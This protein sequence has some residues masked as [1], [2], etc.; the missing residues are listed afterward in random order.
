MVVM[1]GGQMQVRLTISAEGRS[2]SRIMFLAAPLIAHSVRLVWV[3]K[4][5]A[6]NDSRPAAELA[7]R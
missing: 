5:C 7:H 4:L 2:V 3:A 6:G 1:G